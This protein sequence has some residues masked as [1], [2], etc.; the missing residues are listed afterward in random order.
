MRPSDYALRP[1]HLKW[2]LDSDPAI[3]R[4]VM[5]D[6]TNEAPKAIAAERSR[7]A[8]EGWGA[9]LLALQSPT[10]NWGGPQKDRGLLVTLTVKKRPVFERSLSFKTS[11]VLSCPKVKSKSS[12]NR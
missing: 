5:R 6:L 8:T 4:Q 7:I 11:D 2:L 3:R 1:A 10:G 9:K 12:E